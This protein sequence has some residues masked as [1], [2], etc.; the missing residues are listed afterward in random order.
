MLAYVNEEHHVYL[1]VRLYWSHVDADN[2]GFGVFVG[3]MG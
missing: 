1:L 3:W 2:F